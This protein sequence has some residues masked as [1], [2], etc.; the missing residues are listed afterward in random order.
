MKRLLCD[1]MWVSEDQAIPSADSTKQGNGNDAD[2]VED[3]VHDGDSSDV[4]FQD[5]VWS[6]T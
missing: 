3:V 2:D 6:A 5:L 1:R 4:G